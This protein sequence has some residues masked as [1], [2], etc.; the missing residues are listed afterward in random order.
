[1]MSLAVPLAI[2]CTLLAGAM[3]QAQTLKSSAGDLTVRTAA[4]GLDHPW[5]L[6]F[7][8]DG[9]IL[10]TERPGRMRVVAADGALSPALVGV[11]PVFAVNQ[12]GLH[13][14]ILDRGFA[15]NRTIYFCFAEP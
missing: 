8:P 10:V 13:D 1:M 4:N 6:A 11:P 5:A 15:S 12:G 3:A 9:R 7:L 2:V 14:V